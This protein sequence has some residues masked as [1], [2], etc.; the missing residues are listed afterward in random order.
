MMRVLV[1]PLFALFYSFVDAVELPL[2]P[3]TCQEVCIT[4]FDGAEEDACS[5][6][7]VLSNLNSLLSTFT[8]EE[9]CDDVYKSDTKLVAA[10]KVGCSATPSHT[11]VGLLPV[12]NPFSFFST[13][14]DRIRNLFG[15]VNNGSGASVD[16]KA[17]KVEGDTDSDSG[18]HVII[19]RIRI[20]HNF[21]P[22]DAHENPLDS[23][24]NIKPLFSLR[25]IIP[26][27]DDAYFKAVKNNDKNVIRI[28][29]VGDDGESTFYEHQPTFVRKATYFFRHIM[30]R[31]L[32]LPLL[33]ALLIVILLLMVKLTI[34]ACRVR[35]HRH[36]EY[37][38]LPT[39]VEAMNVKVPL[40]E[41]VIKC[42]KSSEKGPI[43]A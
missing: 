19:S 37:T 33:I 36:I 5:R 21:A 2:T 43:D 4:K 26:Q 13:F 41:D 27:D 12:Q 1:L 9:S 16:T 25:E 8:C 23:P 20:F 14:F 11:S 10:C 22:N 7:C 32:L 24:F 6:G 38:R 15:A 17:N 28:H 18:N 40:Y 42:E 3:K 31:P 29:A 30:F 35:E 34:H 39:Y